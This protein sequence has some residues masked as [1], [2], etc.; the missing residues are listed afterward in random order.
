MSWIGHRTLLVASPEM[1]DS[2]G[3]WRGWGPLTAMRLDIEKLQLSRFDFS[4]SLNEKLHEAWPLIEDSSAV[5][6]SRPWQRPHLD[7]LTFAKL[8]GRP[9]WV[10]FDD[11]IWEIPWYNP[12]GD[13]YGPAQLGYARDAICRAD[14]VTVSTP[15]LAQYIADRVA[16]DANIQLVPNALPDWYTWNKLERKKLIVYRGG[17]THVEDLA[18]VAEDI[19][20]VAKDNP[21]WHFVF[22]GYRSNHG[23]VTARMDP[24][25]YTEFGMRPM[26]EFHSWLRTSG[27]SIMIV[28][29]TDCPFNRA[30]SNISWMEG[31]MAGAAVL[32][33]DFEEFR[34]APGCVTYRS[35]KFREELLGLMDGGRELAVG[36]SEDW[37]NQNRR[38][39]LI[40]G[41]RHNILMG[42]IPQE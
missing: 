34:M 16:P 1:N 9:T 30:K 42:L 41:I 6:M 17:R 22:C 23:R 32:A 10:D 12:A 40:N 21:D 4:S 28:P 7:F 15:Y 37:I 27:A 29:L 14:V 33:P 20:A 25:Q 13:F 11:C 36:V 31:T 5:F 3:W 2:I 35:G 8:C 18:S 39:S 38:L 19:L 24:K 26:P